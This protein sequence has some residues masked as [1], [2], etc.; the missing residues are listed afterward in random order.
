MINSHLGHEPTIHF[1]GTPQLYRDCAS[2]IFGEATPGIK[3]RDPVAMKAS[4][5]LPTG[6]AHI[7][8]PYF[9]AE[10]NSLAGITAG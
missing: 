6:L 10:C 3:P 8:G 5:K 4:R 2:Q 1:H 9:N 7:I